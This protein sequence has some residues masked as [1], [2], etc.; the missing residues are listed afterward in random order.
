LKDTG[1]TIKKLFSIPIFGIGVGF[2]TG[3][4]LAIINIIA[5]KYIYYRL[6]RL[7]FLDIKEYL[8]LWVL[9]VTAAIV[10]FSF[11]LWL[12]FKLIKLFIKNNHTAQII[13]G[14]IICCLTIFILGWFVSQ[15]I[16]QLNEAST[17]DLKNRLL[18]ILKLGSITLAPAI[19]LGFI[20][21]NLS[22]RSV[23]SIINNKYVKKISFFFF[24]ILI[25]LNIGLFIENKINAPTDPN[26]L[27]IV[28][29]ALRT[30]HLQSYGYERET[31]PYISKFADDSIIFKN[32][33]AN[34]PWTKP[35]V[36]TIFTGLYPN[37]HKAINMGEALPKQV[38]TLA[39][40]L[41]NKGY[42]T[43]LI[44]AGNIN[45]EKQYNFTQ[46]FDKNISL[47]FPFILKFA[48][49]TTLERRKANLY[50][51]SIFTENYREKM[52]ASIF[53]DKFIKLLS[54]NNKSPFFAYIHF[55]DTH[56]PYNINKF[57]S[58]FTKNLHSNYFKPEQIDNPTVRRLTEAGKLSEEDKEYLIGLLGLYDGQIR[59][60]DKQIERIIK[61]LK[62]TD[63]FD[64]TIIF[65]T[66]DHGEEFWDHNNFEHGH[67]VYNE[68]IHIPLIIGGYNITPF[69]TDQIVQHADFFNTITEMAHTNISA[70]TNNGKS[71]AD[72]LKGINLTRTSTPIF[73]T[74]TLCGDEKYT[75]IE[76]QNKIIFNTGITDGKEKLQGYRNQNALELYSLHIDP[77]ER[78][79]LANQKINFT[80][81]LKE[82]L[83]NYINLKSIFKTKKIEMN[84]E[85]RQRLKSLGYI[86]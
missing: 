39:E 67:T 83:D 31:S 52:K 7:L 18:Y 64:N 19:P 38:I 47:K 82:K 63:L 70:H 75:L 2:L 24:A 6:F 22:T 80:D 77:K 46:G 84:E 73:A 28:I 45:I 69:E 36:A 42:K 40:V 12:L 72:I 85:T 76:D 9:T 51:A 62:E 37:I 1:S 25:F 78:D 34:A 5:N 66:S 21:A 30:D 29:D 68:L 3:L 15:R 17:S 54:K 61:Y 8:N 33:Y 74:A 14:A 44:N 58:L 20:I 55:M 59:F 50:K 11:L 79:D 49:Q 71:F 86:Q 48:P 41:K 53:T 13:L 4:I 23:L 10:G 57:N 60:V 35:S 27:I 16:F 65:I 43:Y 56:T 32:A 81:K 26:F